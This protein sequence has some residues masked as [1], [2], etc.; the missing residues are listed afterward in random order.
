[1]LLFATPLVPKSVPHGNGLF[2]AASIMLL[3]PAIILCGAHSRIGR[4]ELALCK[5]AGRMS[6]PIY[7]LHYPFLLVYMNFVQFDKPSSSAIL[8]VGAGSFLLV[9]AASWLA[10]KYYDEP[11]RARLKRTLTW[12]AAA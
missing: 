10:L 7:I 8:L 2:E 9:V 4:V 12:P 5:F 6:Y 1:V 11:V 3:F